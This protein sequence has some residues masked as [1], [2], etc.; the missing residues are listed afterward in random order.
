MKT[1][2]VTVFEVIAKD[3]QGNSNSSFH[4]DY[5]LNKFFGTIGS[6]WKHKVENQPQ[7][8]KKETALIFPMS[9]FGF[10]N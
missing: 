9:M 8:P 3:L 4:M 10:G 1:A 6:N 7:L 2:S 5:E